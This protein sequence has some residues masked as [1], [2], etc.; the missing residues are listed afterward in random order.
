MKNITVGIS[1]EHPTIRFAAEEISKYLEKLN[2][3]ISVKISNKQDNDSDY[4]LGISDTIKGEEDTV[5]INVNGTKGTIEGS[6]PRSVLF[7]V[8]KYLNKLGIDWVRHGKDGEFV[9]DNHDFSKDSIHFTEK[10]KYKHR[11]MCTEGALSQQSLLDNIDWCAKMGF[12]EYYVQGML[13]TVFLERW[14]SHVGN[15]L[16][17][18]EEITEKVT[19]YNGGVVDIYLCHNTMYIC[20]GNTF[21]ALRSN[22]PFIPFIAFISFFTC[23]AF[24]TLIAL[25][26]LFAFISS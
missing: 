22:L 24:I 17:P 15:P 19:N 12:N 26:P 20:T 11:C 6:N 9:P 16:L 10:A 14:H 13:P 18:K 5:S 23:V 25:N 4:I 21:R 1:N 2:S 8:Y 7:A 3:D